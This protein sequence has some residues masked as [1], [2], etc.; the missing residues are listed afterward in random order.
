MNGVEQAIWF[1]KN[2]PEGY[3]CLSTHFISTPDTRISSEHY[4]KYNNIV[5]TEAPVSNYKKWP[6]IIDELFKL[7]SGKTTFTIRFRASSAVFSIP[8]F[9]KQLHHLSAATIEFLSLERAE[10]DDGYVVKF[11]ATRRRFDTSRDWSFGILWDGKNESYLKTFIESVSS[12]TKSASKVELIICGPK[13]SFEIELDHN[14]IQA[15]DVTEKYANISRKKN[16]IIK[17]AKYQNICVAH[18]RYKLDANFIKSFERINHDYDVCVVKQIL[19][20]TG[21]RVPD[22]VSQASDQRL[23]ANYLLE[24]GEYSPY[25]YIPGGLVIGKKHILMAFP[26]NDLGTWNMAEDVEL[27]QRLIAADYLPRLNSKTIARVLQLRKEIIAD[28]KKPDIDNFYHHI[29]LFQ[30]PHARVDRYNSFFKR[31]I[32]ILLTEPAAL[33]SKLKVHIKNNKG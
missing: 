13:P 11:S 29:D 25:I 21:E 24:Y 8:K 5:F 16:I 19:N 10:K 1:G 32:K 18:N 20:E 17:H 23:T 26:F 3:V 15:D 14:V 4:N 2:P 28:F 7:S 22:W 6:F 12:L 33:Y 30:G 9:Y 27:S 31:N